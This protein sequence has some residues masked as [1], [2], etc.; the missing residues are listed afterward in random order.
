VFWVVCLAGALLASGADHAEAQ[1]SKNDA[2]AA[3]LLER[4]FDNL[5]ADDYVQTLEMATKG[6]SGKG[7]VRKLQI[8]RKQSTRP[9]KALVRFLEP[10]AVRRTSVLIL[11]RVGES[12]D[13]YVYLPSAD[14]TRHLSTAQK[15]D[16]FFGTDLSYE[17]IEPKRA[18]DYEVRWVKGDA[19]DADCQRLEVRPRAGIESIYDL[20]VYCVEPSRSV[21]RWAEFRKGDEVVRRLEV[22][23]ASVRAVGERQIPF[24]MSMHRPKR[25]S[26]TRLL[27]ESYEIRTDIPEQLFST[28]NLQVGDAQRDRR[29]AGEGSSPLGED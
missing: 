3:E 6:R 10:Y 5:Y 1:S 23:P 4:A 17:D 11:E 2:G 19:R 28:W 15:A 16:S 18:A 27:T 29:R 14:R 8:T 22:N 26:S 21:V 25:G 13:L 12:D 20:S 7:L 24:D 9:G